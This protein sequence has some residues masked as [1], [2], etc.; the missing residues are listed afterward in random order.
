MQIIGGGARPPPP[1]P[2]IPTAL[3]NPLLVP[4]QVL[5][6]SDPHDRQGVSDSHAHVASGYC[7]R[8]LRLG[9][10]SF[11]DLKKLKNMKK[12]ITSK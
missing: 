11:T 9:L 2:P 10:L 6:R 5:W 7:L 8:L 4:T 1:C 3:R 12:K